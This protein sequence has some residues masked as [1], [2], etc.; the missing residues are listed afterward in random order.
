MFRGVV[1]LRYESEHAL[2]GR[3]GEFGENR[4]C[5]GV[6]TLGRVEVGRGRRGMVLV[7]TVLAVVPV[8]ACTLG[9]LKR[10]GSG[11]AGHSGRGRVESCG[12]RG[13]HVLVRA[14]L[15][16]ETRP[17]VAEPHLHSSFRQ[18]GPGKKSTRRG[19]IIMLCLRSCT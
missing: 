16:P 1:L 5:G 7:A 4:L 17:T 18:L 10:T 3:G 11:Q 14:H 13:V 2:Q 19:Y 6:L 15:F 8:L 12:G 9:R